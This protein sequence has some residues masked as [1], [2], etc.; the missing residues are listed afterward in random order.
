MAKQ[1]MFTFSQDKNKIKF[2]DKDDKIIE[3]KT[4][5]ELEIGLLSNLFII[6]C[7]SQDNISNSFE[8]RDCVAALSELKDDESIEFT[9]GDIKYLTEAFKETVNQRPPW[10]FENCSNILRQIDK[11]VE[12]KQKKDQEKE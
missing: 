6:A 3:K 10:W 5:R 11:P 2:K 1:F 12:R 9:K 8:C 4:I 7:N